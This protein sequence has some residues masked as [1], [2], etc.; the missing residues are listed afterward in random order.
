M[1]FLWTLSIRKKGY[2][3]LSLATKVATIA[4]WIQETKMSLNRR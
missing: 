4:W 3:A 2:D 1:F